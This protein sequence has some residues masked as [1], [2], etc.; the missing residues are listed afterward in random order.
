MADAVLN[1]GGMY[2]TGGWSHL[3]IGAVGMQSPPCIWCFVSVA[4]VSSSPL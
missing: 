1:F 2:V 3:E 4:E